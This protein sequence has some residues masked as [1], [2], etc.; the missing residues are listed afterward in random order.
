MTPGL[1]SGD[2]TARRSREYSQPIVRRLAATVLMLGMLAAL[3]LAA[4]H[5]HLESLRQC[6]SSSAGCL[7]CS[8]AAAATPLPPVVVP[9]GFE[10]ERVEAIELENPALRYLLPL[11]HSGCA[12]PAR[13]RVFPA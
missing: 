9:T 6:N 2:L 13:G 1:G 3:A 5:N 4:R 10:A 8:G 12:P 7:F 11:A